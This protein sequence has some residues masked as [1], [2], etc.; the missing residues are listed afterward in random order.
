MPNLGLIVGKGATAL[1]APTGTKKSDQK[2]AA[3]IFSSAG[4]CVWVSKEKDLDAVTALSGS[5][6]GFLF[7]M[8]RALLQSAAEQ[9][10]S[11]QIALP[12]I[13]QT[14]EG[15]AAI[16]KNSKD[17]LTT[18]VQ[19]VASKGG[20]TEAGLAVLA[21]HKFDALISRM[22]AAATQRAEELRCTS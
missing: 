22:I 7:A 9:G 17:D 15:A 19:R 13:T 1:F 8:M 21:N 6:P 16:V 11:A 20:T 3:S 14:F 5:G 18:W 4:L 12:L 2:I 10:L